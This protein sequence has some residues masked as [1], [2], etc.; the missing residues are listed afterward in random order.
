MEIRFAGGTA[1]F[2]EARALATIARCATDA[3]L[4]HSHEI[5][6]LDT[7]RASAE[8][9]LARAEFSALATSAEARDGAASDAAPGGG[10]WGM[11]FGPS[12]R[13]RLLSE[14]R[15]AA[16]ER[17]E[18]AERSSFEALAETARVARER[19]AARVRIAE[20]ELALDQ[21]R[22]GEA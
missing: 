18:R 10:F 7:L 3:E 5:Q 9:C 2:E 4:T 11:F 21:A 19:D 1:G 6:V 12:R 8:A 13:E 22:H 16:L 20:L 17:A 14:Q 15:I